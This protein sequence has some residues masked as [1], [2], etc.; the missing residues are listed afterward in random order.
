MDSSEGDENAH[1][2]H[3]K[4]YKAKRELSKLHFESTQQQS[5]CESSNVDSLHGPE[6]KSP[7]LEQSSMS[8]VVES[9]S[10]ESMHTELHEPMLQTSVVTTSSGHHHSQQTSSFDEH[11]LIPR[12]S[13]GDS[14]SPIQTAL[15]FSGGDVLVTPGH[16]PGSLSSSPGSDRSRGQQ[17]E[18]NGSEVFR[19]DSTDRERYLCRA[20]SE[21]EE[22]FS[23]GLSPSA[24]STRS[25]DSPRVL[26]DSPR[27]TISPLAITDSPPATPNWTQS[28]MEGQQ[29]LLG[30]LNPGLT[31]LPATATVD[32]S[33]CLFGVPP[34]P[35]S[36]LTPNTP[37]SPSPLF[38]SDQTFQQ[39]FLAELYRRR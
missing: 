24:Y 27:I 7:H 9:Y 35:I 12:I 25:Y 11:C 23:P 2:R 6:P 37:I 10:V 31:L 18:G 29:G 3:S 16:S 26:L 38:P 5:S 39:G 8:I 21:E 33:R 30:R 28:S 17:K 22:V 1:L 20:I 19:F 34:S 32:Q 36:P 4:F 14:R 15:L 13:P